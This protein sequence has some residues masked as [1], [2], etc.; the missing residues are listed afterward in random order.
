[1][2]F[3]IA[4]EVY[5]FPRPILVG[6]EGSTSGELDRGKLAFGY[7]GDLVGRRCAVPLGADDASMPV[8]AAWMPMSEATA[9]I[10]PPMTST[11]IS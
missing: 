3:A 6:L 8:L 5:I 4:A 9:A 7:A 2:A 11:G 1:M 10:W